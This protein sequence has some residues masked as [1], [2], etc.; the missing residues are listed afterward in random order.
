MPVE[1]SGKRQRVLEVIEVYGSISNR[2]IAEVLGCPANEVT[3]RN[4]ELRELGLV[5]PDKK[6]KC[7]V[8]GRKVWT[9]KRA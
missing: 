6:R 4:F 9:W 3:G 8:S 2:E 1:K 7:R 5:K